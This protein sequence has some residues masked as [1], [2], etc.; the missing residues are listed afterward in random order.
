M[1]YLAIAISA[2]KKTCKLMWRKITNSVDHVPYTMPGEQC[3][4]TSAPQMLR[5][6]QDQ[7]ICS[8]TQDLPLHAC[9]DRCDVMSFTGHIYD[10]N[11]KC[12]LMHTVPS[13]R[14]HNIQ[15]VYSNL[16]WQPTSTVN[17]EFLLAAEVDR[18]LV[19]HP[20]LPCTFTGIDRAQHFHIL[21]C[22]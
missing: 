8:R 5:W 12:H 4:V 2:M 15:L 19:P 18:A 10:Y 14:F 17:H 11:K 1:L 20:I 3:A 13:F 16:Q 22:Q 6:T 7:Y 21:Y 9:H